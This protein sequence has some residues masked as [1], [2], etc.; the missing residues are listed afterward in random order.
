MK[1][2]FFG[3]PKFAEIVLQG[4]LQSE[5]EVVGVVC[6]NDKPAGRGKKMVSPHIVDIARENGLEVYQFEKISAH[7]DEFKAI[8]Y[9]I[10]V[11]ASYGKILPKAFL[12]IK[13][14]ITV[15]PSLLPKYF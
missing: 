7:I 9:D 8:D 10:A 12:D 13:P 6:Q 1:V 11:T 14:C 2:L 4:L 3:T 15:H 5:F